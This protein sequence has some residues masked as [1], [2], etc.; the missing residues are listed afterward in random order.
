MRVNAGGPFASLSGKGIIGAAA[1]FG[2]TTTTVAWFT[3]A[4]MKPDKGGYRRGD[5]VSTGASWTN[6][7]FNFE[8]Q[9]RMNPM[10]HWGERRYDYV[11]G[12]IPVV[13]AED[14]DDEDDE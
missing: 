13:A 5:P 4:A 8:A 6:A 1:A 10:R 7:R 3:F 14:D 12:G 9:Q 11:S 2:I